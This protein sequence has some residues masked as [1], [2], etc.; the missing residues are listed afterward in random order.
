MLKILRITALMMICSFMCSYI[1]LAAPAESDLIH[2]QEVLG[3]QIEQKEQELTQKKAEQSKALTELKTINKTLSSTEKKLRSTESKLNKLLVELDQ[4]ETAIKDGEENLAGNVDLLSE[5]LNTIYAQGNVHILEVLLSSTSFTDFLTRWDLVSRLAKM[6]CTLIDEVKEQISA[7][8]EQKNQV[9]VKKE[10]LLDLQDD[11]S[12]Q[13]EELKLASSRQSELYQ[14][15]SNEKEQIEAALEDLEIESQKIEE[16]LM[17]L[18]PNTQ[19]VGSGSYIW[20]TP[21]HTRITSPY[22]MRR[23]PI[24]RTN[25]MHTGVDIGAPNGAS[26]V[27][28]D[29]GCVVKVGWYGAYGRVVMVD[30]GNG[31]VTMYA[32]T[33]A[34]LVN[35]GDPVQK[36]QTIAKVG[37]TGWSTGPHLHFEVRI[38]GKYTNP[39][40][41]IKK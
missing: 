12:R 16:E 5:R 29:H 35:V 40:N 30:H 32:H 25:R 18:N 10:T 27:A 24:L 19:Y 17:R 28:V 15:I 23:H 9:L 39:L 22:G 1:A 33:S 14:N 38:N 36:G 37:S 4:L 13:K 41:Y 26:I 2:Q 3:Q 8:Q 20:P 6:D 31:I 7:T 21:G 11:Q 34:A